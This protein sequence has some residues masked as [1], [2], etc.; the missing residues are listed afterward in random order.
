MEA[1]MHL[2]LWGKHPVVTWTGSA[3]AAPPDALASWQRAVNAGV[4]FSAEPPIDFDL[5]IDAMLGIGA[6]RAPEGRMAKW[7]DLLNACSG[8][9][10]VLA[11]DIPTGLQADTGNAAPTY[12]KAHHCL[13]LLTLKPGLFSGH[14]RDAA[15]TVWLDDLQ[16]EQSRSES[17]V[18][19]AWLGGAP[20]QGTNRLHASHKGSYGDVA[21]VGGAPGMTGAAL[22]AAS[23]ALHAGAGRV[24][25]GLLDGGSLSMDTSQPELMFRPIEALEFKSITVVCGCG[26]G[27]AIRRRLPKLLS[28]AAQLVID[29]DALNAIALDPQLQTLLS[30]RTK[31]FTSTVLT[32]HPLEAARLLASTPAQVQ[33]DRLTAARHL[34]DRFGCTVVLKGSGTVIAAPGQTAVIN[35]TG[36]ARLATAG[37]GDVLA[38]L[39]GAGLAAGLPSWRVSCEAVFQHG[40]RADHWPDDLPLTAGALARSLHPS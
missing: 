11:V 13:S 25:V 3:T 6:T 31:R 34:A 26:G 37:T 24:F 29:A 23:A 15:R 35:P 22:L 28:S 33:G 8:H 12:V 30:A 36:N 14:G 27:D 32:P 18:P 19:E 9:A 40:L 7:I 2:Q 1:A 10:T 38:G 4:E 5:G 21:I 17:I 16:I 39:I 20:I